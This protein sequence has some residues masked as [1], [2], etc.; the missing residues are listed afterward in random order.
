MSVDVEA[1]S[2]KRLAQLTKLQTASAAALTKGEALL[3][4]MAGWD[5]LGGQS[6]VRYAEVLARVKALRNDGEVITAQIAA[7]PVMAGKPDS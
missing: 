4:T 3:T 5:A 1:A 2:T 7:L 6:A